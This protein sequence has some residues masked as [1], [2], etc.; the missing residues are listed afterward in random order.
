MNL[1]TT[2]EVFLNDFSEGSV[3]IPMTPLNEIVN[4]F[5]SLG[6]PSE[7]HDYETNGWQCDFWLELIKV[8]YLFKVT[9]TGSLY[10]GQFKVSKELIKE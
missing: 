7:Y 5:H 4:T 1:R 10:Y 3:D 8:G 9:V 6:F 2:L